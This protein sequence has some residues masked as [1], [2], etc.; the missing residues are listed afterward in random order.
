MSLR[1]QLLEGKKIRFD[2]TDT[3]IWG[4]DEIESK[5]IQLVE[6]VETG[7]TLEVLELDDYSITINWGEAIST[8]FESDIELV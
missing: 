4:Y 5:L 3:D 1:T 8:L 7:N 6:E 2:P